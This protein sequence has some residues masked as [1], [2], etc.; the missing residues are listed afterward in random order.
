VILVAV[1]RQQSG[2]IVVMALPITHRPPDDASTAVEMP[3]TVKQHLG[4]D[5]E[6]SR[7]VVNEAN[8]FLWPGYDLRKIPSRDEFHYGFLPPRFF[9]EIFAAVRAY[10]KRSKMTITP[11]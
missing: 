11:R 1:E 9:N 7:V 10:R 4:L 8:Q 2:E 5:Y 6:R 3:Q